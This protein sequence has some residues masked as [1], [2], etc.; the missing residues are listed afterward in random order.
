MTSPMQCRQ[1]LCRGGLY[2]PKMH[3]EAGQGQLAGSR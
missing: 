2:G 3:A 1:L